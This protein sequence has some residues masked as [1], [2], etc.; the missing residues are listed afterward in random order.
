MEGDGI[1]ELSAKV[2]LSKW[3]SPYWMKETHRVCILNPEDRLYT[4]TLLLE[5]LEVL[6]AGFQFLVL[7]SG[8]WNYHSQENPRYQLCWRYS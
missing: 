2:R 8:W 5:L 3:L 6:G 7:D 4:R 1:T